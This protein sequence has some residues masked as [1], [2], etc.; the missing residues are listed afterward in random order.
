[1]FGQEKTQDLALP[2]SMVVDTLKTDTISVVTDSISTDSLS[3]KKEKK[4]SNALDYPVDFSAADSIVIFGDGRVHLYKEGVVIY[5][6]AQQKEVR[7]DFVSIK[8]DSSTMHAAGVLDSLGEL[9]GKPVFKDGGQEYE[10]KEINYN[11]KTQKGYIRGAK[12]Q[13][14]DGYIIADQTKKTAD[15]FMNMKGGKYTTCDN[16][17]HPH[18]YLQLTK[19]KV[20]PGGYVAAGPA[21]MVLEDVPLPLALPFG[22]FPF[23][24]KYSSGIIMPSYGDEL[25]NGFFLKNGGYYFAASDYFDLALTGDIYTKGSW[26]LNLQSNYTK[27]YKFRGNINISY[28]N[29]VR[30]E[31]DMPDYSAAKNFQIRWTHSQDQKASQY[32]TF[33]ASV[34]FKTSGYN[35][36]EIG[37][38][39]NA[40]EQSQNEAASSINY[41]QRFPESPFSFNIN[42]SVNQRMKDSTL[43]LVLPNF[44]ASLSQIYP[45]K[46]K[47]RVGKEKFYEKFTFSMSA[48]FNNS[49]SNVKESQILKTSFARDWNNGIDYS[50]KISMPLT[51]FKYITVNPSVSYS[52]KIRFTKI[53]QNWNTIA[54]EIEKDTVSGFFHTFDLSAGVSIS[55]KMYGFYS[56]IKKIKDA[57][58]IGDIRHVF[59]PSISYSYKPDFGDPMWKFYKTYEKIIIDKTAQNMVRRE[60]VQYSPY[61]GAPSVGENQMMSFRLDNNLEMKVIDKAASDTTDIPVYKTVSLIDNFNIGASYNFAKDSLRLSDISASIRIKITKSYTLNLSTTFNPYMY[62]LNDDGNPVL[63]NELRSSHGKA[64]WFNGTSTSFSYTLNNNTFKKKDKKKTEEENVE[65]EENMDNY[66]DEDFLTEEQKM[67]ED[68]FADKKKGEKD[69]KKDEKDLDGYQKADIQWSLSLSLGLG[70]GKTTEFDKEKMDYKR[71]FNGGGLS[72]NGYIN[73]TANWK[74]NFTASL[75][76]L[77]KVQITQVTFNMSR[78]LHCW[79]LSAS[80]TPVG[81]YKSFM[82]TIGANSSLLQDLKYDKRSDNSNIV[83]FF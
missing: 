66:N 15:G 23:T 29:T 12:T 14:G 64:P 51:L 8:M 58:K 45:L 72:I 13:E 47:N 43:S 3:L 7:A 78:D 25:E 49:I 27:R 75:Q 17:D 74:F 36:N 65:D 70:Y 4:N 21:Y 71:D 69:K 82:V 77:K 38:I 28:A 33:S 16:H 83:K 59:T 50:P 53:E 20:K 48:S 9:Q 44:S 61:A 18:F 30:G 41:A 26:R 39:Y 79:H 62:G 55:T 46:K 63:I 2:D 73:P 68:P 24:S 1:M 31:K 76:L 5:K 34:D 80:V 22:F 40:V 57:L 67:K 32:S 35:K 6:E 60:T 52:G 54:Q 56:P 19:G 81:Y 37:Y 11:F 42:A 10:A